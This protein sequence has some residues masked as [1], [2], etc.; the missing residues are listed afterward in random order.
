[1]TTPAD[2]ARQGLEEITIGLGRVRTSLAG[3]FTNG[4]RAVEDQAQRA[5]DAERRADAAHAELRTLRA[6]IRSLGGDPT[7]IQNLWAQLRMRTRQWREAK[8]A[9]DRVWALHRDA[10]AGTGET[11]T[12]CTAG[13]GTW[14]CPT[15]TALDEPN[16]TCPTEAPMDRAHRT[17]RYINMR[18]TPPAP[19]TRYAPVPEAVFDDLAA[20]DAAT[21]TPAIHAATARIRAALGGEQPTTEENS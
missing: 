9:L 8:A 15:L 7:T 18:K 20:I 4:V 1:M 5:A 21:D 6:G 10:Y 19:R 2:D 3:F 16:T 11:G 12:S 14:P 17:A 13:C